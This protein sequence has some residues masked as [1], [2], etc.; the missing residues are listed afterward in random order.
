E[1]QPRHKGGEHLRRKGDLKH[2]L[3]MRANQLVMPTAK[4]GLRKIGSNPLAQPLGA[5]AAFCRIV[6]DV[7][8]KVRNCP[9]AH[10]PVEAAASIAHFCETIGKPPRKLAVT[11]KSPTAAVGGPDGAEKDWRE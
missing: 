2:R 7:G 3:R 4:F 10:D 9:V 8:V 5:S 6:V 11:P 1:H